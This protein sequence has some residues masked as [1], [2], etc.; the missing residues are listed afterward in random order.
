M[1]RRRHYPNKPKPKAHTD[2]SYPKREDGDDHWYYPN[3]DPSREMSYFPI[4]DYEDRGG[5]LEPEFIDSNVNECV[6]NVSYWRLAEYHHM[7]HAP[8]SLQ[9]REATK[10]ERITSR[11]IDRWVPIHGEYLRFGLRFPLHPFIIENL[12][13]HN[14]ALTQLSPNIIRYL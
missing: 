6:S 12:N 7:I 11:P 8:P 4:V 10:D 13:C 3:F 2:D 1:T 9:F 5:R 14:I